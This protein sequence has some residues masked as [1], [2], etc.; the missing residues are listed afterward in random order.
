MNLKISYVW[1]IHNYLSYAIKKT[2]WVD[3]Y[4]ICDVS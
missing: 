4:K 1:T 2:Q 3:V